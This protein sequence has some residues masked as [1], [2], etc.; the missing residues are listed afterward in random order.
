MAAPP[1]YVGPNA[2]YAGGPSSIQEIV[3]AYLYTQYADDDNLQAL[4]MSQ[5]ALATQFLLWFNTL[6]LPIYT[7]GIISGALLDW[8]GQGLYGI[9]RPSIT[10]GTIRSVDATDSYPTNT[11][12][13]NN[14]KITSTESL[15]S[16]ND[17]IYRRVI[18]WNFYKGDGF[19]F[20]TQWL[21]RRVLRFLNG[22]NGISPTIDNTYP[23]SVTTSG[24][25]FTIT[26][27]TAQLTAA[28]FLAALLQSGACTTP[29]QY[30]F[31]L[32]ATTG[33]TNVAGVLHRSP[34]TG[35][36]SSA[37]GLPDG[38]LWSNS[39]VVTVVPGVTPNP[40]AA[41]LYFGSTD[42]VTLLELGG[43]NLPTSNPGAGSLQLWN[44]ANVVHV[45]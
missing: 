17:D 9:I 10:T 29:F 16:V 35:Y 19:V 2:V 6:N 21:K 22:A 37:S 27:T 39:G 26:C 30:T 38:A 45:A 13:T 24:A 8:V 25:A 23:I 11:V 4:V 14:R 40:N 1:Q 3:P 12:A 34:N 36:P 41:P 42:A 31:T 15:Q 28:T 7:G 44:D 43:G 18:T 33:L 32:T 5:N 20:S